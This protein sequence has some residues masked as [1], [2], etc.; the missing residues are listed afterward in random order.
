MTD[1]LTDLLMYIHKKFISTTNNLPS[2]GF[3][4]LAYPLFEQVIVT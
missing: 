1:G 4:F 3:S 2:S